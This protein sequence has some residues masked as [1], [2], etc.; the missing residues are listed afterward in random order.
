MKRL[1]VTICAVALPTTAV[2]EK[3]L[4]AWPVRFNIAMPLGGT[5]GSDRVHGFSWGF[6]AHGQGFVTP[7]GPAF[8]AYAE[9]LLDVRTNSAVTTGVSASVPVLRIVD[10]IDWSVTAYGGL[11]WIDNDDQRRINLGVGTSLN[12]PFYFYQTSVG[13]RVDTTLRDSKFSSVALLVDLDLL[14]LIALYAYAVGAQ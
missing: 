6:R 11:R 12:L 5:W 4:P 7:R 8:G 3:P 1:I 2:A 13:V 10:A 9:M 14:A